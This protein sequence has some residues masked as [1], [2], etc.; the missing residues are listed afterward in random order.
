MTISKKQATLAA[1]G[2]T[3]LILVLCWM[4]PNR[5]PAPE[6]GPSWFHKIHI[7]KIVHITMFFGFAVTWNWARPTASPLLLASLGI[8]LAVITEL[9]QMTS[10]VGRDGDWGDGLAD[11]F[12]VILGLLVWRKWLARILCG[13]RDG[14]EDLADRRFE[15]SGA[16]EGHAE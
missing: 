11:S 3:L 1:I 7:D 15:L 10:I 9:G 14:G 4:P 13:G 2:W 8:V 5:M 12:G 6:T 16:A